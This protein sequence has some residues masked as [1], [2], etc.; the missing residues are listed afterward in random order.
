MKNI[1]V[2]IKNSNEGY[3]MARMLDDMGHSP[4]HPWYDNYISA[5]EGL[6]S[7]RNDSKNG[8]LIV[9]FKPLRFCSTYYMEREKW[10]KELYTVIIN[11]DSFKNLKGGH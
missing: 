10:G 5:F 2:H 3:E 7:L 8:Q 4:S 6:A 9:L 1:A 11:F